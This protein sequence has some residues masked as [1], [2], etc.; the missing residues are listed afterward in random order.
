MIQDLISMKNILIHEVFFNGK[1]NILNSI[2]KRDK[3]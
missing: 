3:K 1:G 2:E